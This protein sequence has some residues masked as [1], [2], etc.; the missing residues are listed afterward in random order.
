[1][2]L[3]STDPYKTESKQQI[4]QKVKK[5]QLHVLQLHKIQLHTK[6]MNQKEEH[7]YNI[8]KKVNKYRKLESEFD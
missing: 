1:M 7:K 3:T 8:K 2:T 6:N 5:G 4:N